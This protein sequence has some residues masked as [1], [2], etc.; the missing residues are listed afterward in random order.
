MYDNQSVKENSMNHNKKNREINRNS[1]NES[2]VLT[3][4]RNYDFSL[5]TRLISTN[6]LFTWTTSRQNETN[7]GKISFCRSAQ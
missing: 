1:V 2:R 6:Y 4:E 3:K 7:T 5:E